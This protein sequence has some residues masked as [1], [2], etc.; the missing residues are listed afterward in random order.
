[1]KA[2]LLLS[3]ALAAC[4]SAPTPV[5]SPLARLADPL[6][7]A[8]QTTL[9]QLFHYHFFEAELAALAQEKAETAEFRK[10]ADGQW[11]RA[12]KGCTQAKMEAA[13]LHF[14]LSKFEH[15]AGEQALLESFRRKEGREFAMAYRESLEERAILA[16][17][18]LREL[19]SISNDARV[20]ALIDASLLD[21]ERKSISAR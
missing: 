4:A 17:A 3:L 9:Q 21:V 13:R 16:G 14:L 18:K 1:M 5:N 12:K 11:A 8:S 20:N 2:E 10:F 19:K 15:T 7:Q 6:P